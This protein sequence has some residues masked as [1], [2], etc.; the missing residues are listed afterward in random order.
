MQTGFEVIASGSV[1]GAPVLISATSS[2][3]TLIHT[4][5]NST[6]EGEADGVELLLSNFSASEV[7][8]TIEFG[9]TTAPIV[10]T[11]PAKSTICGLPTHPLRNAKTVRV[12]AGTTNVISVLPRV[13]RRRIG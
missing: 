13:V 10:H 12:F 1:D 6:T 11:V 9:N 4:A 3:G 5:T 8:I 2:P 7:V